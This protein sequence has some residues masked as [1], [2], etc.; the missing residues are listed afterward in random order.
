MDADHFWIFDEEFT[1]NKS[2]LCFFIP[3]SLRYLVVLLTVS[4][5][6]FFFAR[7]ICIWCTDNTISYIS[8]WQNKF[9]TATVTETVMY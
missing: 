4:V 5:Y 2:Q 1:K 8:C 3:A 6:V 7:I 9:M